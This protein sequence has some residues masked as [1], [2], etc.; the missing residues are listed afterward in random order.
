MCDCHKFTSLFALKSLVWSYHA[1][2]TPHSTTASA[3]VLER[4][5]Q[6]VLAS[7][8]SILNAGLFVFGAY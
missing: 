5:L 1:L 7:D 3:V 4:V 6:Y 2:D 8:E